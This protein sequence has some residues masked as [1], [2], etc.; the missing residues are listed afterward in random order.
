MNK[1][2]EREI[3]RALQTN[4]NDEDEEE[5]SCQFNFVNFDPLSF[6]SPSDIFFFLV[7]LNSSACSSYIINQPLF[8][9]PR[10]HL[11]EHSDIPV[12]A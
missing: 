4:G 6:A 7:L 1:I 9:K 12:V 3:K 2:D 10:I 8:A 11:H 5:R